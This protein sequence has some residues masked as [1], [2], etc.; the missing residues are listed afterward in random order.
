[1]VAR[2]AESLR[3]EVKM[4]VGTV[5]RLCD[6]PEIPLWETSYKWAE[7]VVP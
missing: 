4:G 1:M 2:V 3:G 5:S 6:L 7:L